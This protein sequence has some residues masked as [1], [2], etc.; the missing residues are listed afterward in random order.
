M[1]G[2]LPPAVLA[3]TA[4]GIL[5]ADGGWGFGPLPPVLAMVVA[6][7]GLLLRAPTLLAAAA[8]TMGVGIGAW[9]AEAT[10]LPLGP[11]SLAA[12]IGPEEWRIS[13]VAVDDPRPRG[14][15]QQVV[16][17]EVVL[18]ADGHPPAPA[19]GRLLVWLPRAVAVAG[20]DRL[21]FSGTLDEPEDFEGFAYREYLARQ[22]VSAISSAFRVE[23]TGRRSAP[24][25]DALS[26]LRRALLG[27][28][29]AVVPEPEAALA[30]GILLGV[31]TGIAPEIN[32]AFAR[33]G[34]THVVAISGWN[35]AIVAALAAGATRPLTRLRGGRWLAALAAAAAVGGYVLLTGASPSVVRAA[36]MAAALVLARLGG[37]RAHAVSALVAAALL[38]LLAAPPVLWDVGFQ[39]SALATAG[40]IWFGAPLEA[41][42]RRWPALVREPVALTLAAQLTTLPVILLNFERLSLVSPLANVVVVPL[43][44]LVMLCSAVAALAGTL[45]AGLGPLDALLGWAAG[46]AAW[47]YLRMMILA[48]QAA[49]AVPLA[50]VDLGAPA[51]LAAAW[52]PG[53]VILH[54]R[55]RVAET[56]GDDPALPALATRILRPLPMAAATLLLLAA[57]TLA[58]RPDGRL[59]LFALDVGQGDALLVVAPSGTTALIDGGP[60]PDAAMRRL[61]D[62]LPFWRRSLDLV[63]LSHPHEDH[64]AGLVPA[65]ERY[66]VGAVL[67]PGRDYENPTYPRFSALARGTRYVVARAGMRLPLDTSTTLTILFPSDG[68]AAA[69]LPEGDINNASVVALLEHGSFSALLTGDAE[70]PVEAMLLQR[71]LIGPVDVLK[72]GHHGSESS[73]T[74]ALLEAARPALALISTGTDNEYGHPH[75]VTLDHL[76]QVGTAIYRTD[77]H[78][79]IEIVVRGSETQVI[80]HGAS[81]AGSIGPWPFRPVSAP[82]S[83]WPRPTCRTASSR[84]RGGWRAWPSRRRDWC[85]QV[86]SRSTST[87]SRSPPCCTTSTSRR[88]ATGRAS[89]A[90]WG[91]SG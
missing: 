79:T 44:P 86:A 13:G 9:R 35:I 15:R 8:L 50:S 54:R 89:T 48:G 45:A 12:S 33:A 7:A 37:S 80:T 42:L 83:S 59:H 85:R 25:T 4:I 82:R 73:T 17:D 31:R 16:L 21:V 74:T 28:L 1:A 72:V 22:G 5:A 76:A 27:G 55:W 62:V 53:L 29:N 23:V 91:P 63:V 88:R 87:S 24:I 11:G 77:V 39:L 58:T 67:D 30:A 64:V 14:E 66:E 3:G 51:W 46:G 65:L 52:Y 78:G 32:D 38:M 20:G 70:S 68:D 69:A 43:V 34:L 81:A 90:S 61:G 75:R 2:L 56:S 19:S 41:R 40:L 47:L 26:G 36:L 60:D 71:G 84:T 57:L 18:A 49:A 10:A 6:A